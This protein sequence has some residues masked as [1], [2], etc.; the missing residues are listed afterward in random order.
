MVI[1]IIGWLIRVGM[2][3]PLEITGANIVGAFFTWPVDL[4]VWLVRTFNKE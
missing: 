4:G 2:M 3:N 1:W